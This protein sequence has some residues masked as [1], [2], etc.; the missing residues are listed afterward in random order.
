MSRWNVAGALRILNAITE[1]CK[2]LSGVT[3]A[4][5]SDAREVR[6][7]C[8]YPFNKSNLLTYRAEPRLSIQS[9][10]RGKENSLE[11]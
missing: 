7:T 10:I 11:W 3:K 8:Q 4:E 5:M 6:G 2:K 1:Y 9:S